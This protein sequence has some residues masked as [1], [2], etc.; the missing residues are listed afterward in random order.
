MLHDNLSLHKTVEILFKKLITLQKI[1]KQ[2][3]LLFDS[4]YHI[5]APANCE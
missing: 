2:A 4:F 5:E 1:T 3:F